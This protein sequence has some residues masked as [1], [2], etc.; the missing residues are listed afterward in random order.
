MFEEIKDQF[1]K[2][3]E[4]S[5]DISNPQVDDLFDKWYAAKKPFIDAMGGGLIWEL[6]EPVQFSL[7][8]KA[9]QQ[10]VEAFAEVIY[11][12]YHNSAL[13]SFVEDNVEGFYEN[14]VTCAGTIG[15]K[16]IPCGMKLVK[17]FKY[18]EDDK[19][20]LNE[21]QM[22]ASEIIQQDRVEGKLCI[23]V[24]P[25]DY[26]SVSQNTYNWRSCHSL[27]GDYRAGNLSYMMDSSTLVCYLK[28]ADN[29]ILPLFPETV[30]WNSKKWR[31]LI[32]LSDD[33]TLMFAGRQYPFTS[34]RGLD[35]VQEYVIRM[36]REPYYRWSEW[37]SPLISEYKDKH[38]K[39]T[40]EMYTK[41]IAIRN[42]I[43]ALDE[44]IKDNDLNPLYF[45]DLL[46]STCYT[47]VM[48]IKD[49]FKVNLPG[50]SKSVV[51]IGGEVMCLQCGKHPITDSSLMRCEECELK[52]GTEENDN[53]SF[54]AS[55]DRRMV[56]EDSYIVSV[57]GND[58][59]DE[60][61]EHCYD[62]LCFVCAECG[63]V[64]YTQDQRWDPERE[65]YVCRYCFGD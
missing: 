34:W 8:E 29:A 58:I 28:G 13:S 25:L 33:H 19:S 62:N 61:C 45:N 18:F 43:Y 39:T 23:S 49:K 35:L 46:R 22:R 14:K 56:R 30:R 44:I 17:A 2:V 4:Y 26:L 37:C 21:L 7:D 27:D 20:T 11:D 16:E 51:K 57:D 41:Q 54:C 32:F 12:V 64:Y 9:K 15:D 60:V 38:T 3:I 1:K 10:Q 5:Q 36:L 65:E 48:S 24:H 59:Y 52:Y 55:C 31:C 50:G 40:Y 53:Y 63:E 6:S 47:P 42:R